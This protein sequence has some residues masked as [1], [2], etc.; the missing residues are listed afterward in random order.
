MMAVAKNQVFVAKGILVG[1]MVMVKAMTEEM[2]LVFCWV[3]S[4]LG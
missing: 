1:H 4:S 3:D 2:G